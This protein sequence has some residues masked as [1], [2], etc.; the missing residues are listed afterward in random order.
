MPTSFGGVA[1]IAERPAAFLFVWQALFALGTAIVAIWAFEMAWGRALRHAISALPDTG[2]ILEGRLEWPEARP[3]ILYQGPFIAVVVDP[4][5]LREYG[6][7]TDFTLSLESDRLALRSFLGWTDLPYPPDF[8]LSLTRVEMTSAVAAWRA[9]FFVAVGVTVVVLLFV[10]WLI[11]AFVYGTVV[12]IAAAVLARPVPHRVARRLCAASLLPGCLVMAGAMA[13]YATRQ[14]GLEGL[15]G[16]WPLHIVIGWLYCAGA[17][18]QLASHRSATTSA[19]SNPFAESEEAEVPTEAPPPA[20]NPF[21][22][23]G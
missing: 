6:L 22:N 21:R 9:P 10:S 4:T 17:W 1:A 5:G 12:W 15:L 14:L 13:L 7:A 18:T 19:S 8:R 16:A 20:P 2:G 3:G 23:S 11:L